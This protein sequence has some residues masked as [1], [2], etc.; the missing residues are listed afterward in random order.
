[1]E[2]VQN[3]V[4]HPEGVEEA[5]V[6]DRI[7]WWEPYHTDRT[8]RVAVARHVDRE[9]LAELFAELR[10]QRSGDCHGPDE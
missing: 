4:V 1:V 10:Q 5:F 8:L 3:N 7:T 9:A 2:S 6:A